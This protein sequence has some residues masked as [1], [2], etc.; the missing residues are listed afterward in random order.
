M[1]KFIE[2]ILRKRN[3]VIQFK[4]KE[5]GGD[6]PETDATHKHAHPHSHSKQI[7]HLLHQDKIELQSDIA[8]V[9]YTYSR[10]K[11]ELEKKKNSW[12]KKKIQ[13]TFE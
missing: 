8:Y 7:L 6:H 12:I 13:K 10:E 9:L 3:S 5:P 4:K 1:C 11:N 2:L